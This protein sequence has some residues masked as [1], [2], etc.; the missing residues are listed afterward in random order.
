L[1]Q[2]MMEET[3]IY[4]LLRGYRDRP[5]AAIEE[6]GRSLVRLSYLVAEHEEIREIDINPLLADELGVLALDARV[7]VADPKLLPRT[8]LAVRPYPV[9]W[10]RGD[11]VEGIG[12]FLL[13]PIRP[14]DEPM[15]EAFFSRIT[16]ADLQMRFFTAAPDRSFRFF[17]RMTQIDYAREMAFVAATPTELLGVA[18]L[19]ADPDYSNAE[20]AVIVRSDLKG[21]GLGYKLMLHLIGYARAEGLDVLQGDVLAANTS[22]LQLC[23]ELGFSADSAAPADVVRVKLPLG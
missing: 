13:R 21:K 6:I 22:M 17:A 1:A 16:S 18:R 23:R 19:V 5:P 8:P 11:S 2:Q 3:R 20:F 12:S 15:Y 4:K 9:E 7:S 14:D 10:E